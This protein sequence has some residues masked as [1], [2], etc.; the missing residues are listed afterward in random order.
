MCYLGYNSIRS[1]FNDQLVLF[2]EDLHLI[3]IY[4]LEYLKQSNVFKSMQLSMID[5]ELAQV[6]YANVY[7]IKIIYLINRHIIK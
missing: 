3:I 4:Q 6:H 1:L 2:P 7:H 5:F